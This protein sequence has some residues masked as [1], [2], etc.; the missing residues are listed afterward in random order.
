MTHPVAAI[1]LGSSDPALLRRMSQADLGAPPPMVALV[2]RLTAA[3]I[4]VTV[5]D[6][7]QEAR[8]VAGLRDRPSPRSAVAMDDSGLVTTGDPAARPLVTPVLLDLQACSSDDPEDLEAVHRL[9]V[10]CRHSFGGQGPI[11]ITAGAPPRMLLECFR[12]G[13]ADVIDLTHEG[14]ARA[15]AVVQ[16]A[17][18]AEQHRR[19]E[20]EVTREQR[21]LLDELVRD[22]V[23]TERRTIDLEERLEHPSEPSEHPSEHPAAHPSVHPAA[24]SSVHP[25]AHPAR[26][27]GVVQ[28]AAN[29]ASTAS[30]TNRAKLR[31]G[32]EP[33]PR[34]VQDERGSMERIYLERIYLERIRSRHEQLLARYLGLKNA[35][36]G[37]GG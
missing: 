3:G 2:K 10:D 27:D 17:C 36:H 9:L 21:E 35:P 24:H 15:K 16:R 6:D 19:A 22:L 1:L 23:R 12:A 11:A 18:T 5:V 28:A 8:A 25:A 20:A 33:V 37:D 13:A 32:S 4:T 29:G 34:D 7:L 14:T 26:S 30:P 31:A